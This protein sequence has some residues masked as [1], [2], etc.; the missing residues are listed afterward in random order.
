MSVILFTEI[1]YFFSLILFLSTYLF[2]SFVDLCL[3][4]QFSCWCFY[5]AYFL[6]L[7]PVCFEIFIHYWEDLNSIFKLFYVFGDFLDAPLVDEAEYTHDFY[8]NWFNFPLKTKYHDYYD[9]AKCQYYDNQS[10]IVDCSNSHFFNENVDV[11]KSILQN[12]QFF[13][14]S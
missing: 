5:I 8:H 11:H 6:L 10:H 13:I 3:N 14:I 9:K 4:H 2:R 7:F 1:F 12:F